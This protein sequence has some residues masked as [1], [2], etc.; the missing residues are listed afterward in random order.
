MKIEPR[1]TSAR[2][3][4]GPTAS[5]RFPLAAGTGR[6]AIDYRIRAAGN[7][8]PAA[9]PALTLTAGF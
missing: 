1:R 4:L 5:L 9:G 2:L 3:D 8:A 6:L 7:A